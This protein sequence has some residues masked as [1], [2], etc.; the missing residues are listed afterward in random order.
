MP[1]KIEVDPM[2]TLA[3]ANLDAVVPQAFPQQALAESD[4]GQQID[5]ALFE[6]AGANTVFDHISGVQI[7]DFARPGEG[8][9][10]LGR[11]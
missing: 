10:R 8:A 3:E 7:L 1:W 4:F 9:G 5:R 11:T 2:R 6:H